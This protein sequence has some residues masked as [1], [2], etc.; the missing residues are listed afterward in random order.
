MQPP[1]FWQ[2]DG[3][4]PRLQA[5]AASIFA[6]D[7]AHRKRIP[8]WQAPVPVICCGAATVGGAGKTPLALDL[9]ARLK[10][11]GVSV[12][13]LS[14]GYGR[15]GGRAMQVDPA[16]HT[17]HAVGDEPLLLAALAPTFVGANRARSARLAVAYGATMLVMDDGL[18]NPGLVKTLSLLT[19]DGGAGFGN[20]RVMPAGPLREPAE[21]TARRCQAAVLIG[22]DRMGALDR[23]PARLPVLRAELRPCPAP[24]LNGHRV[25]AFAGIARPEKFFDSVRQAGAEL[26]GGRAFADHHPYSAAELDRLARDAAQAGAILLTTAKDAVRLPPAFAEKIAVLRVELVWE[27]AAAPDRLLAELA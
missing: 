21:A 27:D 7:T 11:R 18:Q 22:P 25:L 20:G 15:R 6:A 13:F 16:R 2:P 14:R 5:P 12:A 19:I 4:L 1:S 26:F 17:A 23:L 8:G 3:V 10:R 9:A 24:E